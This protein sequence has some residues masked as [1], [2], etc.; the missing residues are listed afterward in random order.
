M[1]RVQDTD[2]PEKLGGRD[3]LRYDSSRNLP[4]PRWFLEWLE[5]ATVETTEVTDM[6]LPIMTSKLAWLYFDAWNTGRMIDRRHA[7]RVKCKALILE[8]KGL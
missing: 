6:L 8:D 4:I 1:T 3:C 2:G 7:L 5:K